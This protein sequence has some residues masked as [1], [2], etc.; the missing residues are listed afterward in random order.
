MNGNISA[1]E[2]IGLTTQ[3]K[4]LIT[5]SIL[6]FAQGYALNNLVPTLLGS[7]LL[8]YLTF[9]RFSYDQQLRN[10]QLSATRHGKKRAFQNQVFH[11]SLE[12]YNSSPNATLLEITDQ[13]PPEAEIASGQEGMRTVIE[14][15]ASANLS[16][17]LRPIARGKL[18]LDTFQMEIMDE[19]GLMSTRVIDSQELTV[20]VQP[21]LEKF[22]KGEI[23][24]KRERITASGTAPSDHLGRG[25][26]FAGLRQYVSDDSSDSIEWKASSRLAKLMTKLT[27]D[28]TR[29]SIYML[30]DC[31]RS[32]RLKPAPGEISKLDQSVFHAAQM[33]SHLSKRGY[34]VAMGLYDEHRVLDF[35]PPSKGRSRP[36]NLLHTLSKIPKSGTTRT[37]PRGIEIPDDEEDSESPLIQRILPFFGRR[38]VKS[39]KKAAGIYAAVE[40]LVQENAKSGV[41]V[42]YSDLKT[43]PKSL[44][45]A[46]KIILR[47]GHLL[48][49][50]TPLSSVFEAR[51]E[52]ITADI[53]ENLYLE[54]QSKRSL[55]RRLERMGA[56][57]I[58]VEKGKE[59]SLELSKRL[60]RG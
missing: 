49:V 24:L 36:A 1:R 21:P 57:V 56:L 26:E 60:S 6:L 47:R 40:R 10:T 58:E 3:G 32:M 38:T 29:G 2:E 4:I 52:D 48:I 31:S 16:Y 33:A 22:K 53:L 51:K 46:S 17:I 13:I 25:Y 27:Y 8:A 37:K 15:Q 41:V 23:L 30:L 20:D 18:T 5:L 11:S 19:R 14:P 42:V 43:N 7:L 44:Q 34:P 55:M 54:Y 28:E 9:A 50:V 12:I 39:S 59:A 45:L 35:E